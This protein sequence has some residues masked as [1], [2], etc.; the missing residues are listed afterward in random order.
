MRLWFGTVL[1]R[2]RYD[3]AASKVPRP[4]GNSHLLTLTIPN[5]YAS[6]DHL[7]LACQAISGT[8]VNTSAG[9]LAVYQEETFNNT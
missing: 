4:F 9:N 1:D 2:I 7:A 6:L 8:A 5:G 3:Y